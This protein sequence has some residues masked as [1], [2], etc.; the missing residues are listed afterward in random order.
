M[1]NVAVIGVGHLG[2]H[3]ARIYKSLPGVNLVGVVDINQSRGRPVAA[4]YQTNYYSDCQSL[5]SANKINAVSI[6]TPTV[7]HYAVAKNFISRGIHT[8]I[9]KPITDNVSD[10]QKLV[11]LAQPKK[12]ILQVGHIERF[13]PA[14]IAIQPYVK[15]PR[16]IECHRLAPFSFRSVDIDVVLDVMI[17]DLD[18]ILSLVKSPLHKI[19]ATGV[20][21]LT[22]KKDIASVRLL[23]K[24]GCVANVTA[25]R[26]S[27][28]SMRKLRI[29]SNDAYIS[30]DYLAKTALV[31]RKA[32]HLPPPQKLLTIF[33]RSKI[34][35]LK[36]LMLEKF[37]QVK[38][39]EIKPVDQL[40]KELE[41]FVGCIRTYR[42][43]VVSGA[44]GLKAIQLARQI[45]NKIG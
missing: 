21:I 43:P 14:F 15:N 33:N 23:F 28:K 20:N 31:Y 36:K 29:F 5:F 45:I 6:A 30:V 19:E 42:K 24:N 39:L 11:A 34:K 1:L 37:L 2:R 9:E 25:S 13:N 35:D 32:A 8:F 22:G 38:N 3:H 17:H 44:D 7:S 18:I 41:S 16:F 27:D 12:I 10:A 4:E 40:Q 26:V